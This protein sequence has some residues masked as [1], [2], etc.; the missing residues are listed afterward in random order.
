MGK[1]VA[2]SHKIV[3]WWDERVSTLAPN[4]MLTHSS[5]GGLS[6]HGSTAQFG[7]LPLAWVSGAALSPRTGHCKSLT[8]GECWQANGTKY[9]KLSRWNHR[10]PHCLR[11]IGPVVLG[12]GLPCHCLSLGSRHCLVSQPSAGK[13]KGIP[14]ACDYLSEKKQPRILCGV[15]SILHNTSLEVHP[16]CPFTLKIHSWSI[17]IS[18]LPKEAFRLSPGEKCRGRD[19]G[20]HGLPFKAAELRKSV[21]NSSK[22]TKEWAWSRIKHI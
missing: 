9:H 8:T 6:W 19:H 2:R 13:Y 3:P 4:P 21:L 18:Q 7:D 15:S 11:L 14:D 5:E 20:T 16:D 22:S 10:G 17:W 12:S 1:H